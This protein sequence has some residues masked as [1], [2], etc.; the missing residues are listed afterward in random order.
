V[1]ALENPE[2]KALEEW[3]SAEGLSEV[4]AGKKKLGQLQLSSLASMV[5]VAFST[6][7]IGQP[8]FALAAA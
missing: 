2:R 1:I 6:R 5:I 8:V 3:S 4:L 7:E